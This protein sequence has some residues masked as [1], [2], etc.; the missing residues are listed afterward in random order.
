M[1]RYPDQAPG[2]TA[3]RRPSRYELEQALV[4]AKLRPAEKLMMLVLLTRFD[5]KERL[6][7]PSRTPSLTE[8]EAETSHCRTTVRNSLYELEEAGWITRTPPPEELGR[9]EHA[10]TLYD[11]HIPGTQAMRDAR[12]AHAGPDH[13]Q[14]RQ[15]MSERLRKARAARET[16][17][18]LEH[19]PPPD[20]VA[21][22]NQVLAK[23]TRAPVPAG[24]ALG[25]ARWLQEHKPASP[26]PYLTRAI[27]N[28]P[29]RFL[30]GPALPPPVPTYD[31]VQTG[32]SDAARAE[33]DDIVRK[34]KRPPKRGGNP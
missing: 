6:I 5:Y 1:T 25:A 18:A 2:M 13:R 16:A 31:P 17:A 22:A 7:P 12:T 23:F 26:R 21:I 11:L 34:G 19:D 27:Q 9:R 4:K 20:L 15:A 8:L 29:G 30:P 32:A 28:D 24:V 3:P 33:L 14:R 10:R